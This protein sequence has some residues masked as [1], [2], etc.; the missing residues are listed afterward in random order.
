MVL[1]V[2]SRIDG[3]GAPAAKPAAKP[4]ATPV[5]KPVSA[6]PPAVKASAPAAVAPSVKPTAASAAPTITPAP[7]KSTSFIGP[8]A[9]PAPVTK[10]TT[11]TPVPS[12][13]S[14]Q[15][16][17]TPT[18]TAKTTA[19]ASAPVGTPN[20]AKISQLD[21]AD[22]KP[23]PVKP[24]PTTSSSAQFKNTSIGGMT[25]PTAQQVSYA[26]SRAG[27]TNSV[28]NGPVAPSA[29]SKV[30][31]K[32][33]AGLGADLLFGVDSFKAAGHAIGAAITGKN[34]EGQKVSRVGQVGRAI[35]DTALGALNAGTTVATF[36][37]GGAVAKEA[38]VALNAALKGS[39]LVAKTATG[40]V[41][42]GV[43]ATVLAGSP[44]AH[45][46]YDTGKAATS[47]SQSVNAS[48]KA[49]SAADTFVPK[50]AKTAT[51]NTAV[52]S[53]PN[54]VKPATAASGVKAGTGLKVAQTAIGANSISKVGTSTA[55]KAPI[56]A[57]KAPT[58]K[59]TTQKANDNKNTQFKAEVNKQSNV[60]QE[61]NQ[62][63]KINKEQRVKDQDVKEKQQAKEKLPDKTGKKNVDDKQQIDQS[64]AN[65]NDPFQN[66]IN[67][68]KPYKN[69]QPG[70]EGG[71]PTEKKPPKEEPKKKKKVRGR[72]KGQPV[73]G[74][75]NPSSII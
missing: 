24:A 26:Q 60:N 72:F 31:A 16:T 55:A 43:A 44:V 15:F 28:Y 20:A 58:T 27:G 9:T 2:S 23:A 14:K 37:P 34:A 71:K 56:V 21:K 70:P 73:K 57:T 53:V 3:G 36:L 59:D 75:W 41:A 49:V 67:H 62:I 38:D 69:E 5:A 52:K 50:A 17:A 1:S 7:A 66:V 4:V 13:I 68:I 65:Y 25:L 42:S 30:T 40:K 35:G 45:A 64:T 32:D 12:P 46:A 63:N 61:V 19:V 74:A 10:I 33:V 51:K 39:K 18:P 11:P 29:P 6:A 48:K 47:I 22:N 54:V 8:V